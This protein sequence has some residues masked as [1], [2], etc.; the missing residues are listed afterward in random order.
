PLGETTRAD[1]S[2]EDRRLRKAEAVGSNPTRSTSIL[3]LPRF[4][5]TLGP[6]RTWVW[7]RL[8]GLLQVWK[9][10]PVRH[11]M[12]SMGTR[13]STTRSEQKGASFGKTPR[14]GL[15]PRVQICR[16]D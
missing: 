4:K 12:G 8:L 14:G 6:S 13:A 9:R 1:R 16:S 15:R 2:A 7:N 5:S 3:Y 11:T 10:A